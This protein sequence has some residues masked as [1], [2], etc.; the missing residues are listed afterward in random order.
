MEAVQEDV[1]GRLGAT[2]G[3]LVFLSGLALL[4]VVNAPS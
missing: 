3:M 1:V 2:F 4:F